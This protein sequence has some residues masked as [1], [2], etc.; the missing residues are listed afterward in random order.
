[1]PPSIPIILSYSI[2]WND[3]SHILIPLYD[4][5]HLQIFIYPGY[6]MF[7][8]GFPYIQRF[9]YFSC[10]CNTLVKTSHICKKLAVENQLPVLFTS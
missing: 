3:P 6:T 10:I 8:E 2:T 7:L 9:D 5:F 4:I 1:M